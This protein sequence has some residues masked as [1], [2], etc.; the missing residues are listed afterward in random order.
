MTDRERER[1]MDDLAHI[2]GLMPLIAKA[3]RRQPLESGERIELRCHLRRLGRLSPYLVLSVVPGSF[4]VL[5]VLV[6]WMD[7][8]RRH[9]DALLP[10]AVASVLGETNPRR[11][12]PP[13]LNR[14]P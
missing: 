4:V 5:P 3:R 2:R 6:W 14:E 10:L 1:V 11:A 12:P 13:R 9:A 8:R 7:R